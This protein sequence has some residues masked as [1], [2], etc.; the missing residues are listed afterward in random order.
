MGESSTIIARYAS[1]LYCI[2]PWIDGLVETGSVIDSQFH[3]EE[4]SK[5]EV[6]FDAALA[7][8]HN[9]IKIRGRSNDLAGVFGDF[10]V[11]FVYIDSLHS[12]EVVR[13]DIRRWWP[14]VKVGG[15]IGGHNYSPH[16]PSVI[17][18]VAEAFG[19]P[20]K[21][22]RDTSWVVRKTAGR[23]CAL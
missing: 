10:S 12:H 14:K 11:D 17:K 23:K 21:L 6:L 1:T 18:A 13:N 19:M 8:S 3:Y 15:H 7:Q 22:Y 16:W 20:D 9:V 4:M 2:D 5:V